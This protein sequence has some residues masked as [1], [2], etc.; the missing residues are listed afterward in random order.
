MANPVE[1]VKQAAI[2]AV[3]TSMPS[4]IF[5]GTVLSVNP[6]EIDLEQKMK[7]KEKA[8]VLTTLVQDFEV[9]M[10][11]DHRTEPHTHTHTISDTFTG[12]GSASN[13]THSHDYVGRKTFVVHLGL[14]PGEK[15]I[16]LREQGGQKFIVL[17]RVR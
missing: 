17:D 10:T 13:E 14:K 1:L 6:L 15:V 12:G 2:E 4:G 5:F 9:D 8:L 7:L 16:L 3:A 11:V